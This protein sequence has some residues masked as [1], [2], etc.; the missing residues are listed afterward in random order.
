M[1]TYPHILAAMALAAFCSYAV[2]QTVSQ[3][4]DSVGFTF[5]DLETRVPVSLPVKFAAGTALGSNLLCHSPIGVLSEN[6]TD[7]GTPSC[8]SVRSSRPPP[9]TRLSPGA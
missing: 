4:G 6:L 8:R 9:G 2:G 3:T 5:T 1:K 7:P